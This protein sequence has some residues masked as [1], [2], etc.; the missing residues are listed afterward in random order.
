MNNYKKELETWEE[1]MIRLGN[2][3]VVRNVALIENTKK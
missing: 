1:K 3:D 2:L